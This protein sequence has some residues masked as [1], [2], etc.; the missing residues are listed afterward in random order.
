MNYPARPPPLFPSPNQRSRR[1]SQWLPQ[2]NLSCLRKSDINARSKYHRRWAGPSLGIAARRAL[3]TRRL[4]KVGGRCLR[5]GADRGTNRRMT[6][7]LPC[8][9]RLWSDLLQYELRALSIPRYPRYS[10]LPRMKC[11][12][13]LRP[14][15][16]LRGTWGLS[17]GSRR[18]EVACR[19]RPSCLLMIRSL[20]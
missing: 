2:G 16:R 17:S 3:D 11:L 19:C 6:T 9:L 14:N 8:R 10:P 7:L 5:P 4:R 20:W 15:L 18:S 13:R 1:S 12:R